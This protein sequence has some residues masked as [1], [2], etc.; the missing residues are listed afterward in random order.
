MSL[1]NFQCDDCGKSMIGAIWHRYCIRC[2]KF[3]DKED[4]L[5]YLENRYQ[6]LFDQEIDSFD[7]DL[8]QRWKCEKCKYCFYSTCRNIIDNHG[9]KLCVLLRKYETEADFLKKV[10]EAE[11]KTL[12]NRYDMSYGESKISEFLDD[13]GIQYIYEHE[14]PELKNHPFDFYIPEINLCIEFDGRQHFEPNARQGGFDGLRKRKNNDKIRNDF[15]KNKKISLI[16]LSCLRD[17]QVNLELLEDA[18]LKSYN[19]EIFFVGY[20]I[21]VEDIYEIY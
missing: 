17:D 21:S 1:I 10:T 14:F 19:E 5:E 20:E 6:I 13:R 15:C 4:M 16:R 7:Y 3:H 11:R 8:E 2:R 12:I 18:M 9:C